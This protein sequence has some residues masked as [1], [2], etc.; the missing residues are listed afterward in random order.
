[1]LSSIALFGIGVAALVIGIACCWRVRR[2][3]ARS[4]VAQQVEDELVQNAQGL[5]LSVHGIVNELD[6]S[7][8]T[9]QKTEQTL[10]RA[11]EQLSELREQIE[12]LRKPEQR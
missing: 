7:D 9:R 10:E 12:D 1:M 5:I 6:P 8:S 4:R 3:R 2:L 11:D